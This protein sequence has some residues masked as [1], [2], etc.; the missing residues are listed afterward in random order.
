MNNFALD[1]VDNNMRFSN[2]FAA[3][4][5]PDALEEFK[6][7][8]HQTDPDVTMAA[9]ANV[10]IVTRAGT[11]D[12]HGS[13]W[14]FLRNDKLT[15]ANFFDNFYTRPKPIF[16]QNQYGFYAGGP[17]TIPHIIDGRKSRTYWSAYF[18]G[19]KY[20]RLSNTTATV[21]NAAQ[22]AG[23][24][25]SLLGTAVGTDCLGRQVRQYQIYD[26]AT[27]VVNPACV[28]AANPTGH[29]RD[30][31]LNNIIPSAR[32]R[33]EA[34]AYLQFYPLPNRSTTTRNLLQGESQ[35]QDAH[36]YGFRGDHYI[37]DTQR[38]FGRISR[39][40]DAHTDPTGFPA[41][42]LARINSGTN[43]VAHYNRVISPTFLFDFM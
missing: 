19:F 5:P 42:K 18:E 20:R 40:D 34:L 9:G 33:P 28:S 35:Q 14:E 4:P 6:V 22:R 11:N 27:T 10:N 17:A 32:I 26:I 30:P 15:A 8:T 12:L 13:V 2:T 43:L 7:A 25:S 38:I 1:G 31:F 37:S 41:I 16:R 3:A 29:V 39:Y 21:P 23:D 36:Q 24:F